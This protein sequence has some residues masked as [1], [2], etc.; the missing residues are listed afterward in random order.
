M[1]YCRDGNCDKDILAITV[2]MFEFRACHAYRVIFDLGPQSQFHQILKKT[3]LKT[4][5]KLYHIKDGNIK[6]W[7]IHCKWTI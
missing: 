1:Q 4:I 7:K 3:I 5:S 2:K 6:R